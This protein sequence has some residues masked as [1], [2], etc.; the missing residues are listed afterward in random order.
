MTAIQNLEPMTEC[1]KPRD[2]FDVPGMQKPMHHVEHEKRL[3]PVIRKAF[4][5]F[6][7]RDVGEPARVADETPVLRII[8]RGANILLRL[9]L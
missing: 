9:L 7:E 5:R 4:P 3:H 8:H 1:R 2:M 6:G